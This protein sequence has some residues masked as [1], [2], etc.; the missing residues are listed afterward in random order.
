MPAASVIR[1][2]QP[3]VKKPQDDQEEPVHYNPMYVSN[4]HT[5]FNPLYESDSEDSD[6]DT[7]RA[8]SRA[9]K[10]K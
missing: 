10:H 1:S 5:R 4:Q 9:S 7:E 3:H 8:Y 2:H 6:S